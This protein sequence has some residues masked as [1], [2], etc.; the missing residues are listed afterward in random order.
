MN[1]Q[2]TNGM[3][4]LGHFRLKFL[5]K[6]NLKDSVDTPFADTKASTRIHSLLQPSS[7]EKLSV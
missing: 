1:I 7:D 4:F 2:I 3:A 6:L 5:P